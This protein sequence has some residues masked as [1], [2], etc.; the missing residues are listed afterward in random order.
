MQK[1][2]CGSFVGYLTPILISSVSIFSILSI[3]SLT[4]HYVPFASTV[5]LYI[6]MTMLVFFALYATPYLVFNSV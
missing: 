6:T 5:I 1:S 4:L 2:S 3:E